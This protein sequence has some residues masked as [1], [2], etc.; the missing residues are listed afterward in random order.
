MPKK[1]LPLP[2]KKELD[3]I[4]RY[5]PHTGEFFWKIDLPSRGIGQGSKAGVI[6]GRQGNNYVRLNYNKRRLQAHRVAW[7]L[8]HDEDPGDL[9]IDHVNGDRLDNRISN[10]RLA[11]VSQNGFNRKIG[12]NNTSGYKGVTQ[13]GIPTKPYEAVLYLPD[14]KKRVGYFTSATEAANAV[15]Q[16]KIK[17]HGEFFRES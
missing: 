2:S 7:L 16:E 17:L 15:N 11:T 1:S 14:G 3:A 12:K 4:W 8:F 13:S 6:G 9:L 10:L 5:E